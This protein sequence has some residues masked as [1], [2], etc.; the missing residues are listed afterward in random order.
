[1]FPPQLRVS[2]TGC[3]VFRHV[4]IES[5]LLMAANQRQIC[6]EANEA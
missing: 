3:S 4:I 1:M 5:L 2:D 6:L